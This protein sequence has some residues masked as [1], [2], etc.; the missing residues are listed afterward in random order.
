MALQRW[1]ARF[2]SGSI[3]RFYHLLTLVPEYV[4]DV[5]S[6]SAASIDAAFLFMGHARPQIAG[7]AAL[8]HLVQDPSMEGHPRLSARR[9]AHLPLLHAA[10]CHYT[11]N[12]M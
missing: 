8:S 6:G 12:G 2:V 9:G 10:R 11:G 3:A 5:V 7:S 4:T 1:A